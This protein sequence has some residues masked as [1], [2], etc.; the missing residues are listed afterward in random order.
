MI[1]V[2]IVVIILVDDTNAYGLF[3]INN[4]SRSKISSQHQL[5]FGEE[6]E[7]IGWGTLIT[8]VDVMISIRKK[9]NV[10]CRRK[11]LIFIV[12]N[13]K[14]RNVINFFFT[15]IKGKRASTLAMSKS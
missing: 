14:I 4:P 15:L 8:S 12:L 1:V 10:R 3:L 7:I 9:P 11:D 6:R 2:G 13:Y 5:D